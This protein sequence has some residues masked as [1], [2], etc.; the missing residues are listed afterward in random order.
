MTSPFDTEL[1]NTT[2]GLLFRSGVADYLVASD[3][4]IDGTK[5]L[6]RRKMSEALLEDRP[7]SDLVG[8]PGWVVN[9]RSSAL[10]LIAS[11]ADEAQ[12]DAQ[13]DGARYSAT[14]WQR[15]GAKLGDAL[16]VM[17]LKDFSDLLRR[18]LDRQADET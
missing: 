8:I 3:I 13:H 1:A 9:T 12:R 11:G 14:V 6:G 18:D 15:A 7:H 5:T 16:V 4:P 10:K 2:R 17:P